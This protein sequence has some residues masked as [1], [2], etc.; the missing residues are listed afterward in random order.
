MHTQRGLCQGDPISPM[1]F[2]II[3][4]V[5]NSLFREA[6]RRRAL[7]PLPGRVITHRASLYADDVVLL[8]S[9]NAADLDCV[10]QILDLFAGASGLVMNFDKFVAVPIMCSEG[11]VEAVQRAFPCVVASFPCRYLGVPLSVRRLRRVDEQPLVDAIAARIPT[12]KASMLTNAGRVL[13]TKVTVSAIP[14]HTSI[15]CC[16]SA[17]AMD[18]IDKRRRAFLWAGTST[19][20]GGECKVA[21]PIVCMPKH[22]GG[23]GVLDLRFFGFA[24]RLRWE[25]LARTSPQATWLKLSCRAEK[26]VAAMTSASM[27]VAVGDGVSTCLWTDSWTAVGPLCSYAPNLFAAI[28]AS[29]KKGQSGTASSRIVG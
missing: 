27:R 24:L 2:V 28:T 1:L 26:E 20:A 8:V 11:S 10:R 17:W 21:W 3:M 7:T 16:L 23:L 19:V 6:D 22:L 18:Q 14:V 13:L 25:W 9:P 29:E 4:E 15:A 5:L 12:W